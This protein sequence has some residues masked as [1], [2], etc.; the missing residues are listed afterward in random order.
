MPAPCTCISILEVE[1]MSDMMK[2]FVGQEL[3]QQIK[4]N[5][6]HLQYPPF[7]YAKV[8]YVQGDTVTLKILGKNK[9]PDSRFPEVP[10]VK[11]RIDIEK[12]DVVAIALLYGELDP[13]ILGRC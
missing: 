4:G 7:M 5:Y 13:Y 3:E 1:R 8:V 9:Q 12:G 2:Q 10:K 6:P 11:T